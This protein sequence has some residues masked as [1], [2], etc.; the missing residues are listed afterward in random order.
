MEKFKPLSDKALILIRK[1]WAKK[2]HPLQ[3]NKK[4]DL[5]IRRI[6]KIDLKWE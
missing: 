6:M 3:P 1:C 5:R 4:I 2:I